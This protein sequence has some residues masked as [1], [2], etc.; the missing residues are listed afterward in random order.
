M[1]IKKILVVLVFCVAAVATS[2]TAQ[3]PQQDPL[4]AAPL[5]NLLVRDDPAALEELSRRF[6]ATTEKIQKQRIASVLVRRLDDDG[7]YWNFLARYA[8]AAVESDMPFPYAFDVNG[9]ALPNQYTPAFLRWA[10]RA[11]AFPD[12]AAATAV[13]FA[14]LD[15]FIMAL[16]DD[17]RGRDLLRTGLRSPNFMVVYRAAWG[18]ARLRDLSAVPSI[19]EAAEALPAQ[20][21]E[22]VARGLVLFIDSPEAQASVDRLIPDAP[23]RDA[24][25]A[26]AR[27]ELQMNIGDSAIRNP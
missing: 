12:Q 25:R 18:L 3:P 10:S 6:A 15:V 4:A 27:Q 9:A 17:P 21:G 26:R 20:G 8:K 14:P 5:E 2:V 11:K 7:E 24:L 19:I 13:N 1:D 16:T 22:M 23:T